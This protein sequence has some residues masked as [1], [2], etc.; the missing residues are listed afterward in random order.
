MTTNHIS[1]LKS[2]IKSIQKKYKIIGR[3]KE[4]QLLLIALK[5]K[6]HIIKLPGR[7]AIRKV[8]NILVNSGRSKT[9]GGS[10]LLFILR[11]F[12]KIQY[13]Q[14]YRDRDS[15]INFF[16]SFGVFRISRINFACRFPN[17]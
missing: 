1:D 14:T 10:L 12:K 4:L 8:W 7:I 9:M 5:A 2:E 6:K 16:S 13:F 3:E 17:P 11:P 15:R